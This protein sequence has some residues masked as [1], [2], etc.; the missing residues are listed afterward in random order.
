MW[1]CVHT[2]EETE[3]GGRLPSPPTV[4][5]SG[6]EQCIYVNVFT[7]TDASLKISALCGNHQNKGEY[8]ALSFPSHFVISVNLLMATYIYVIDRPRK[9]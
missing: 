1:Q 8:F 2:A 4:L 6:K 7:H 5:L 3:E 9:I